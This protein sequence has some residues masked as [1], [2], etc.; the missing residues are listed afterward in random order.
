MLGIIL[1]IVIA[2]HFYRLAEKYEKNKWLFGF[3]GIVSYYA[4][5]F[6][7][8]I[9]LGLAN[10]IFSLNINFE[11]KY[12]LGIIAM[13]FGIGLAYVLHSI[14]KHNL[15]EQYHRKII[16]ENNKKEFIESTFEEE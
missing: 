10:E 16:A 14:L 4:G 13:P 12:G 3:I 5:T 1:L 7:V 11:N 6:I 2:R 8:G 9:L 15:K